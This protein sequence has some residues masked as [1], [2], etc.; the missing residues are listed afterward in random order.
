M[1]G[2]IKV[3]MYKTGNHFNI[4]VPYELR[5]H[6]VSMPQRTWNRRTHSYSAPVILGNV[7]HLRHVPTEVI[8]FSDQAAK[9]M[10]AQERL[11]QAA[12]E[13]FPA[14][15]VPRTP[16]LGHQKKGL[17]MAWGR[18]SFAWLL[19]MGTGKSKMTIDLAMARWAARQIEQ[20]VIICPD[21]V[22]SSWEEQFAVHC[23]GEYTIN[24]VDNAFRPA[25]GLPVLIISIEG[26][27]GSLRY[28]NI[29]SKF[30]LQAETMAV[31]DES[32]R[33]KNNKAIGSTRL[34]MIGACCAYRLILNGTPI[35]KGPLDYWSQYEFL[36][37]NIIGMPYYPFKA[38]YAVRGGYDG[39]EV[40]GYQNI[41][42]LIELLAPWTYQVDK[43]EALKD[44]PDK[45]YEVRHI[46]PSDEQKELCKKIRKKGEWI[47]SEYG[48][49]K[50]EQV[51]ERMLRSH[52]IAGGYIA[53]QDS[54][55]E[56]KHHPTA[57][58]RNP[59]LEEL[60]NIIE[61]TDEKVIVWCKYIHEAEAI[62]AAIAKKYGP[63]AP[64]VF[65]GTSD[66]KTAA[67]RRFQENP[68]C[69]YFIGN[70]A[71]GG[72]GI[73][74]TAAPIEV[75]YTGTFAYI[76]RQQSEDRAHRIGQTKNVLII[77]M[78]VRGT[79]DELIYDAFLNKMDIDVYLR[80]QMCARKLKEVL[81][82]D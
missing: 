3:S 59:K 41:E 79:T 42:E 45:L 43:K 38:R 53:I 30:V 14:S 23:P 7:R 33:I 51:L 39:R 82:G 73:T 37:P 49:T 52:Q 48:V 20:L 4:E 54:T 66:E 47:E 44:L 75:Y 46:E 70:P 28:Y 25:K 16:P 72:L 2:R 61:Q 32:S 31:C 68:A 55:D 18:R 26:L 78:I 12:Q 40:V 13:S 1:M 9:A 5:H 69:R 74:L 64:V 15:Y 56:T 58:K 60:M 62:R 50:T 67:R 8:E 19:P 80:S 21:S 17:D 35:A 6:I 36:D 22:I 76:D 57:L 10:E 29:L 27:R 71:S 65:R 24:G 63:E 11:L 81:G 77:D 34:H